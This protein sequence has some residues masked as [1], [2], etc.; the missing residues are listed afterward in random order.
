MLW[1]GWRFLA[2]PAWRVPLTEMSATGGGETPTV[3]CAGASVSTPLRV[4]L[5]VNQVP[6]H[7]P[8]PQWNQM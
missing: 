7:E 3:G 8:S 6:E 5:V 4:V 2:G 1:E